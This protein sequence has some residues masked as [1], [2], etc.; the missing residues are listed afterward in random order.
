MFKLKTSEYTKNF[1]TFKEAF[2][3]KLHSTF[4]IKKP[5][6][7]KAATCNVSYSDKISKKKTM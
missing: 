7:R 2:K 5:K 4:K 3:I 1:K 6:K